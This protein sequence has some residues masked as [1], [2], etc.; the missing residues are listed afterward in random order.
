MPKYRTRYQTLKEKI[1][2]KVFEADSNDLVIDYLHG[3]VSIVLDIEVIE[4]FSYKY[5]AIY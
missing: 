2:T 4:S 1:K 3:Q 5:E